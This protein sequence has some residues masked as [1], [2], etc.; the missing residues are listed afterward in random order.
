MRLT[1]KIKPTFGKT[2]DL[3][4]IIVYFT[5]DLHPHTVKIDD[6]IAHLILD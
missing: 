1:Y 4:S 6:P 3:E 2:E 5:K